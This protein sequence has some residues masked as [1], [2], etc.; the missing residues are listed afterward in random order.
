MLEKADW[1]NYPAGSW[2]YRQGEPARQLLFVESGLIR[3]SQVTASGESIF[4]CFVKPAGVFGYFALATD[5]PTRASAQAVQPSR[6]AAWDRETAQRLL[7]S[8][9]QLA[10]NLF[11]IAAH[12]VAHFWDRARRLSTEDV[13]RRVECALSE[14]VR[15]I[16]VPSA[17]GVQ[18]GHGIGQKEL[19]ELAGTTIFTVSRVLTK[20]QHQGIWTS[21]EASFWSCS[22]PN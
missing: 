12:D 18:I 8:T 22:P 4:I 6:L 3:L 5:G 11:N 15:T 16:G 7:Q 20:L 9:P 19:A 10:L 1:A 17:N 13:G 2:L 21:N 14:L